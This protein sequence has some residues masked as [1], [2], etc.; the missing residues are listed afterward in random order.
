MIYLAL[1]IVFSL[2]VYLVL[3][4][5]WQLRWGA[6]DAEVARSLPG[7]DVVTRP[8]F[9]ATRAITIQARPEAVWP[10]IVQIGSRRAGWYSLDQI[11][12][13]G[14]PSIER[15]EPALQ[16][17]DVGD[18]VPMTPDGK[19]GMWVKACETNR[20]M[21]WW[22]KKADSTWLW[23]LE[24]AGENQTRLLTRLRV[25]YVWTLP[26]VLYYLLQD[27][28]DIVM[29]R[30]CLLGIKRRAEQFAT[31]TAATPVGAAR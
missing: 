14:I 10:W 17:M 30:K 8:S 23:Q 12:N 18:F 16:H 15:I 26:W 13:A 1:A 25:R 28:G 27:V 6:T 22:D 24:P 7:D 11:D 29:M 21:L 3:I 5:P 9:N 4:R 20:T 2:C 31:P 19:N